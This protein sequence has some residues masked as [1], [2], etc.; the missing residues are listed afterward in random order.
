MSLKYASIQLAALLTLT[1]VVSD[2]DIVLSGA[3]DTVTLDSAKVLKEAYDS[4]G[5]SLKIQLLPSARSLKM[6]NNGLFDGEIG[7]IKGIEK[8]YANLLLVPIPINIVHGHIFT[9]QTIA[10]NIEVQLQKYGLSHISDNFMLG[11]KRG[12]IFIQRLTK[13]FNVNELTSTLQLFKMLDINRLDAVIIAKRSGNVALA[14]LDAPKITMLDK[15]IS[16][17]Y[18]YHYLHEKN[19]H[20]ITQLLTALKE[21]IELAR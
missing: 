11:I 13:N 17:V 3:D 5:V 15:P 10:P 12:D 9:K 19:R 1:N 7:R 2:A 20:L 8:Q 6:A 16:S 21:T 14:T 18:L 4:I